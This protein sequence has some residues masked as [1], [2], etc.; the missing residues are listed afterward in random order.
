M[1]LLMGIVMATGT[2]IGQLR[3]LAA[4]VVFSL[5]ACS[6]ESTPAQLRIDDEPGAIAGE[7]VVYLA[8]FDDG[9]AEKKYFL[10]Q[11]DGGER[12]LHFGVEP[13]VA[14]G[15]HLKV[16][17]VDRAD[18][19]EISRYQVVEGALADE[20]I[21][22]EAQPL[23]DGSA[24]SSRALCAALVNLNG[25][26]AKSTMAT[27]K[28]RLHAGPASA[29]AFYIENSFGQVDLPGE[30]Y[31]PFDFS[32]TTCDHAGLAKTLRP[33]IDAMATTKCHQYAFVLEPF[34]IQC[35]W[36]TFANVG[37]TDL[38]PLWWTG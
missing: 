22:V 32:M 30:V 34:F 17:G 15:A 25:G 14:P 18:R 20:G 24:K 33:Q 11:R 37:T 6:G 36:T 27:I 21:G 3:F 13:D 12:R 5:G 9:T 2:Q 38:P 23:I 8:S 35:G 31:G 10:K 4:G 16:W 19:I 29:N 1:R 7:F 28:T 26:T